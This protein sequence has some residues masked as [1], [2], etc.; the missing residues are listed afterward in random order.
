M[1]TI[2]REVQGLDA[3]KQSFILSEKQKFVLVGTLLGDGAIKPKGRYHRLHIKHSQNQLKLAAY[4]REVF[5]NITSMPVRNFFQ[6]VK[7]KS[8]GFCEFVTLTH[9]EFSYF[10]NMFYEDKVKRVTSKI[11]AYLNPLS[12]AIW[13][14]DDGCAE[15]AGLSFSTHCFTSKEIELLKAAMKE[16]F[17]VDATSRRNKNGWILYV[18]KKNVDRFYEIVWPYLLPEFRYKLYPYST[19]T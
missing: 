15:Y 5:S 8:Y 9:P 2:P 16:K 13:F 19:R 10:Y 6:E 17:M 14:M 12:L 18:P 3:S 11:L 4:K 1:R 7:G